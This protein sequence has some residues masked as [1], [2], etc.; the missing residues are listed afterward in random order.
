MIETGS[1]QKLGSF[2]GLLLKLTVNMSQKYSD[3]SIQTE[4]KTLHSGQI[5]YNAAVLIC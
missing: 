1:D 4:I 3:T 5:V 2:S